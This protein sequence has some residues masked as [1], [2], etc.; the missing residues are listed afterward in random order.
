MES[1]IIKKERENS[2]MEQILRLKTIKG[3]EIKKYEI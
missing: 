1:L 3:I 2:V